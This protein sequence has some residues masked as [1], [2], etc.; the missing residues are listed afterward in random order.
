MSM[1]VSHRFHLR[2][3][4]L[5]FTSVPQFLPTIGLAFDTVCSCCGQGGVA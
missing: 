2:L 5:A 1:S 4:L 3:P